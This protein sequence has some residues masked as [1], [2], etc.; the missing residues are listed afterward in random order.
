[1]M[2]T[3]A[4]FVG[5]LVFVAPH[6]HGAHSARLSGLKLQS[7]W[8]S[9]GERRAVVTA[10][11]AAAAAGSQRRLFAAWAWPFG[12]GL[13]PTDAPEPGNIFDR[14]LRGEAPADVV[15][16]NDPELFSFRDIRPASTVHLLVIPRR[17]V[18]DASMLRGETDAALVR[19]MERKARTLVQAEVGAANFIESELALGFHWPPWYSVPW[20]HLHAIYPVSAMTRRYK[21]TPFSFKS[22]EWV[23]R[24][25]SRYSDK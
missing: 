8:S 6:A 5:P 11:A 4:R 14:I 13:T 20:L 22:P 15:E 25:V 19:Q 9:S 21:Y 23:L 24:R 12:K 18:R 7:G 1:M 17:F 10:L 16:S 2:L 3:S